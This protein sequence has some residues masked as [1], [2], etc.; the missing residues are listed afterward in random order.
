MTEAESSA[1]ATIRDLISVFGGAF[2]ARDVEGVMSIFADDVVSFDLAPPLQSLGANAL[3]DNWRTT[4]ASFD[5]PVVF[6]I[7]ELVV[8]VGDDV[9]FSHSVTRTTETLT[10]GKRI[11]R[12][13]RWT[14][15]WRKYDERRLVVHEHVSVPI[16]VATGQA[17][18]ELSP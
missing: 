7:T 12:C 10:I 4:F 13:L 17:L 3:R 2:Q 11:E 14:A 18:T 16:V 15:C 6:D 5:G 8:H 9:A 1:E